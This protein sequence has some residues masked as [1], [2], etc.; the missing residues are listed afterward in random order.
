[1][2]VCN[3]TIARRIR[4]LSVAYAASR[5]IIIV[6]LLESVNIRNGLTRNYCKETRSVDILLFCVHSAHLQSL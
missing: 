1:M 5:Y 4:Y 2:A 3:I 6:T